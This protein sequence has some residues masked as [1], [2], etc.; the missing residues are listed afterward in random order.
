MSINPK[1]ISLI[2]CCHKL[3][4]TPVESPFVNTHDYNHH[5]IIIE[6]NA[7]NCI[8]V[9][10]LPNQDGDVLDMQAEILGPGKYYLRYNVLKRASSRYLLLLEF[11]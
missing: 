2:I 7:F 10:F 9:I 6:S 11:N 1:Q 5:N 3:L 8:G 4:Q